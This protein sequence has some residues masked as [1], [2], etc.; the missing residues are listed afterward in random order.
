M[1][2][3]YP[4]TGEPARSIAWSYRYDHTPVLAQTARR[5]K[6]L[7]LVGIWTSYLIALVALTIVVSWR[8]EETQ[9]NDL[10]GRRLPLRRQSRRAGD[11]SDRWHARG[12][13]NPQGGLQ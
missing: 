3:S 5:Q 2:K 7:P 8:T 1:E 6:V 4:R 11:A 9:R 12:I 10:L 13:R